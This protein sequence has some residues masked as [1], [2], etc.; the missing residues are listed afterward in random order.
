VAGDTGGTWLAD[1]G[2][3]ISVRFTLA[4]GTTF[5][6][7]ANAWAAGNFNATANQVNWMS[8]SSS[9]TFRITGV[10]L[11]AGTVATPFERRSYGQELA[12]C[13]RYYEVTGMI[14]LTA[15]IGRYQTGYWATEKRASPTL[16]VT[17]GAGSG[18]AVAVLSSAPTKGFHQSVVNSVDVNAVVTGAIEL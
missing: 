12:L 5:Q 14:A 15:V 10:Q 4:T 8:S 16:T 18:A 3:G 11:E 2:I 1:S 17:P 13:Q 6:T 9:R 7:T